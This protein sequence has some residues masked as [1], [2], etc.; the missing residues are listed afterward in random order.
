MDFFTALDTRASAAKLTAPAPTREH[1]DRILS[2]GLRAPD[3]GK[4]SPWRFVVLQDES[5][6]I[7]GNALAAFV[8][9]KSPDTHE[10]TLDS[11]RNKAQRAPVIVAV[12]ARVNR[13]HKVPVFEQQLAA[14]AA[15]QNMLLAAHALGYGAMW[16][17]GEGA[18][19]P[20]V[21]ADL[22]FEPDDEVV[23]FVYLGTVALAGKPR[24]LE[25]DGL[26]L[27]R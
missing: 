1:L 13:A 15:V 5:R 22:G 4:L 19:D 24:N 12:A 17:T 21:K 20:Q 9:R 8:K 16:K 27:R 7:L 26:V 25:L 14:A 3:H 6:A 10:A 2:A 23:A 18:Y 11:E